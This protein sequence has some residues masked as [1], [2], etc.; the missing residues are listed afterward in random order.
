MGP[1][2]KE[3]EI[4][5][6]SNEDIV[7]YIIEEYGE[8]I[9]RVI[10][11]YVKNYAQTDDIF[12]EFLI[13]VYT[14]MDQFKKES[15]LKTWLYRIAINKCK[16]YLRSP[17]HRFLLSNNPIEF[18]KAEQTTEQQVVKDEEQRAIV[19]AILS[20]PIM[21]REVFVLKF[22]QSLS[23]KQ[24]S[25]TLQIKESTVKTRIMRGKKKLQQKLGGDFHE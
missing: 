9:K 17:I 3:N 22:Y 8:E 18:L 23:I 10:F 13:K 19:N 4:L 12:Q 2:N 7:D 15:K 16:D 20:L 6:R 21:Y 14:N 11:T 24:I 25:E 5:E 1:I